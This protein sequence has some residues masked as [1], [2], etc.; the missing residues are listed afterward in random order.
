MKLR[1]YVLDATAARRLRKIRRRVCLGLCDF[2]TADVA[3]ETRLTVSSKWIVDDRGQRTE[4]GLG[5]GESRANT[6]SRT[7][8]HELPDM[9]NTQTQTGYVTRE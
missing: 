8:K 1:S 9:A 2:M 5:N 4:I 7:I 3:S 6:R